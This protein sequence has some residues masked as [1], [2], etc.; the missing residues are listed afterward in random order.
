PSPPRREPGPDPSATRDRP[1]RR[2]LPQRQPQQNLVDQLRDDPEED[3][4]DFEAV[5]GRTRSTLSAFRKGT[6]R[7]RESGEPGHESD[8][9]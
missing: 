9:D 5:S 3:T 4:P 2:P 8:T 6:R 1:T 7:G